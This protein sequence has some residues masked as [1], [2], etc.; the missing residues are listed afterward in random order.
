ML[1]ALRTG[2]V[3]DYDN[4]HVCMLLSQRNG[5]DIRQ[6]SF[7]TRDIRNHATFARPD[8]TPTTEINMHRHYDT[9]YDSDSDDDNW[10][11]EAFLRGQGNPFAG[12]TPGAQRQIISA[13]Y[14]QTTSYVGP[15]GPGFPLFISAPVTEATLLL[16]VHRPT[17]P[18][19]QLRRWQ[20][21]SDSCSLDSKPRQAC[22]SRATG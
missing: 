13:T 6:H 22:S 9:T 20:G 16:H 1:K 15:H 5:C 10:D 7:S 21:I 19:L 17:V 12:A 8:T 3:K 11:P 18:R 14:S 4:N 2:N